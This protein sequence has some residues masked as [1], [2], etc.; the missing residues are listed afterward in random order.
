[1]TIVNLFNNIIKKLDNRNVYCF[2]KFQAGKSYYE[3]FYQIMISI[4][5][6]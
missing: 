1:M 5:L 4:Y 2:F 6:M 3:R